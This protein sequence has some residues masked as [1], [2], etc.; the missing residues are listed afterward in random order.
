[1]SLYF[2]V[3]DLLSRPALG[4]GSRVLLAPLAAA[5]WG[6]AQI[7]AARRWAYRRGVL[8]SEDPGVPVI[9]VGNV[10]VG[11]TGK[12][13][14][15]ERICRLLL[16]RGVRPAVLSRGYGGRA[17]GPVTVV[18][19]GR[20]EVADWRQAGDEPVLLARRLPEVA[21][22]VGPDRR[23][24]ARVAVELGAQA[25]VL[26]DGFQHLRLRRHLDVVTVDVQNPFGNGWCLPRGLLR[27]SPRALAD[28]DLVLLTR[29]RGV[30]A[31]RIERTRELVGRYAPE[32][33]I[34][35]TSHDPAGWT[36]LAGGG[37]LALEA[38][39]GRKILAFAGIGDPAAFFRDLDALGL[40]VVEAVP[41]PD[42]HPYSDEDREQLARW[43]RL[44]NA[45]A[46]VTTE[47]DA[48]RL[49]GPVPAGAPT[50]A[51][52]IRLRV[53]DEAVLETALD[54]AMKAA[55]KG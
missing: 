3:K 5:G 34:L 17:E 28:A 11:G 16:A 15:V 31:G 45:E 39:R 35:T 2:W 19:D 29:T 46:L 4:A 33:P 18:S 10:A 37:S 44:V 55:G 9:S 22:V 21:V 47:K 7:Q 13:P 6:Y 52:A 23:R 41:F 40:R 38:L 8:R 25:L 42:H 26:D 20:G 43:A 51:L 36:D 27:E 32:A 30:P 14:C 53:D 54:R 12:T 24:T 48:V 1:M 50:Y 49:A